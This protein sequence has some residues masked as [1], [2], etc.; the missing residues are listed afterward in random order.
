MRRRGF[1]LV[2]ILV[3]LLIISVSLMVVA[4]NVGALTPTTRLTAA[5]R[6][7]AA[8]ITSARDEAAL[9]GHVVGMGYD[10]ETQEYWLEVPREALADPEDA[11][12]PRVRLLTHRLPPEVVFEDIQLAAGAQSSGSRVVVDFYP[13]GT[14]FRQIVHLHSDEVNQ[15]IW[16]EVN[17]LTADTQLTYSGAEGFTGPPVMEDELDESAFR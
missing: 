12:G 14:A 4:V 5:A 17:P 3:V 13:E 10:L 9:G 7:V 11:E 15:D 16:I 2:E 8:T 6:R 1:T